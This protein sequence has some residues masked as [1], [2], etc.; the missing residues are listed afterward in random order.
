MTVWGKD[1][2]AL[3]AALP[4]LAEAVEYSQTAPPRHTLILKDIGHSA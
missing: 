1:A 4:Q 3:E 2:A